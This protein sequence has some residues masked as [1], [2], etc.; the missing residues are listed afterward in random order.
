MSIRPFVLTWFRAR[1]DAL[2]PHSRRCVARD[3]L[4]AFR[5]SPLRALSLLPPLLLAMTT[6]SAAAHEDW[7]QKKDMIIEALKQV[8]PD[9]LLRTGSCRLVSVF[10][11]DDLLYATPG[12]MIIS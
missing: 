8:L 5:L 7:R 6:P 9:P 3:A 12:I 4:L 2:A 1:R 10:F 11:H